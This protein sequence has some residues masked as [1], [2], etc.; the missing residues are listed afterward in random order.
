MLNWNLKKIK[1]EEK[2]NESKRKYQHYS[3]TLSCIWNK[4]W[5]N[6]IK[7]ALTEICGKKIITMKF[8]FEKSA[9]AEKKKKKKTNGRSWNSR[10]NQK[11]MNIFGEK[12]ILFPKQAI[13]FHDNTIQ[14]SQ[15]RTTVFFTFQ[16]FLFHFR[17]AFEKILFVAL[18]RFNSL[19][20]HRSDFISLKIMKLNRKERK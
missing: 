13:L 4:I 18:F 12:S 8:R 15:L 3:R 19:N 5:K 1:K 2:S 6:N 10:I 20:S 17:F 11:K 16:H 7:H 9:I 14:F